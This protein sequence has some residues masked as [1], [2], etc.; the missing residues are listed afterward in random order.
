MAKYILKNRETG[1][2][3]SMGFDKLEDAIKWANQAEKRSGLQVEIW[4]RHE[5]G[6]LSQVVNK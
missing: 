1:H 6:S 5:D 4:H 2:R 3:L